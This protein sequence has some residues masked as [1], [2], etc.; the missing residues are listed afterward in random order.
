MR[1]ASTKTWGRKKM[2]RY[3][4]EL[5]DKQMRRLTQPEN[6]GAIAVLLGAMFLVGVAIGG[7][8]FPHQSE[9]P[10][11]TSIEWGRTLSNRWQ[12]ACSDTKAAGGVSR[13]AVL[14]F[15][16]PFSLTA[17]LCCRNQAVKQSESLPPSIPLFRS[18]V[19]GRPV[20]PKM[21][22]QQVRSSCDLLISRF[23]GL[24]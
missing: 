23:K 9:P 6:Y 1:F 24:P 19:S 2:D 4:Q 16:V 10:Q 12:R 18:A 5:L 3:D 8:V 15:H 17:A 13:L 11:I 7:V 14:P 20:R 22:R 21:K